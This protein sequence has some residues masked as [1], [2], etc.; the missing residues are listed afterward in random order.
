L[1]NKESVIAEGNDVEN[2]DSQPVRLTSGDLIEFIGRF[3][4][5][6]PAAT[7]ENRLCR[8]KETAIEIQVQPIDANREPAGDSFVA[9]THDISADGLCLYTA[10]AVETPYL[11]VDMT[12]PTGETRQV[13]RDVVRCLACEDYVKI[14]CRFVTD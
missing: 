1:S 10:Q 9:E 12:G 14:G 6:N 5:A 8:R 11:T 3:H 13:L 4:V 2:C 7:A